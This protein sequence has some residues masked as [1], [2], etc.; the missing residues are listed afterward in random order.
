M[1]VTL[2]PVKDADAAHD[3]LVAHLERD[4]AYPLPIATVDLDV[5]C[6]QKTKHTV[7]AIEK[8][9]VGYGRRD[10]L[11][12][13]DF[14]VTPGD[15]PV[16]SSLAKGNYVVTNAAN[17]R[18]LGPMR[19]TCARAID[20][21]LATYHWQSCTAADVEL[22][23]DHFAQIYAWE[24][25]RP[26]KIHKRA[27][28]KKWSPLDT[29]EMEFGE[30]WHLCEND[31]EESLHDGNLDRA[32]TVFSEAFEKLWCPPEGK[33]DSRAALARVTG[34]GT[35]RNAHEKLLGDGKGGLPPLKPT[36]NCGTKCET[37]PPGLLHSTAIKTHTISYTNKMALP[38]GPNGFVN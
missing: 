31:S 6:P 19:K 26:T 15:G 2:D 9:M 17:G 22:D 28:K 27:S 16:C 3:A 32:W 23:S 10:F 13:G 18:A 5:R 21:G 1:E 4:G 24:H 8:Q 12:V 25:W 11:I 14:N 29:G 33:G 36:T 7:S 38:A 34:D 35:S 37:M 20:Y 30:I